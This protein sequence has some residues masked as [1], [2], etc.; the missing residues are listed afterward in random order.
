MTLERETV[1]ALA[2]A[3]LEEL[4][5][6]DDDAREA[7]AVVLA[8]MK[9]P[10][11]VAALVKLWWSAES[12]ETAKIVA[13]CA[14]ALDL[15]VLPYAATL[16]GVSVYDPIE[17][18]AAVLACR[19]GEVLLRHTARLEVSRAW[20]SEGALEQRGACEYLPWVTDRDVL[21]AAMTTVGVEAFCVGAARQLIEV[22]G[23][24]AT[25]DALRDA[26][27]IPAVFEHVLWELDEEAVRAVSLEASRTQAERA[28]AARVLARRQH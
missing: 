18:V 4:A 8:T 6:L 3:G 16:L 15:P 14:E 9:E 20:R 25:W 1:L 24:D 2:D 17:V 28:I 13:Q 23:I 26:Y 11:G 10:A 22:A 12:A 21:V 19:H 7:Y 5:R 27:S